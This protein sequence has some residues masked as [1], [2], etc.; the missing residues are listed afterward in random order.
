VSLPNG[1]SELLQQSDEELIGRF[2]DLRGNLH[3]HALPRKIGSWH[4][5]KQDQF[6]ADALFLS[7]VVHKVAIDE[8][9]PILYSNDRSLEL[10]RVARENQA[11]ISLSVHPVAIDQSGKKRSLPPMTIELPSTKLSLDLIQ[12]VDAEFHKRARSSY[13][14]A[15]ISEYKITP[16]HGEEVYARYSRIL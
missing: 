5:E 13:P 15:E 3:H 16:E 8:I 4:P 10:M 14:G 6:R 1:F 7:S 9:F 2:V 11:T 12:A